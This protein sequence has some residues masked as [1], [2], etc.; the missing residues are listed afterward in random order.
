M[1]QLTGKCLCGAVTFSAAIAKPDVEACHCS[2]CRRWTSGPFLSVGH[3]GDVAF[4]GADDI[5]VYASSEWAE[6]AFCR[7]CGTTLYYRL[8]GQ[9]HYAFSAGALDDDAA[10]TLTRQIFI[11][12]KPGYYDFANDTAKL[13]GE[14][15]FAAF[16]A[17]KSD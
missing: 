15:V 16:N 6:R 12:E 13:T 7:R 2:M 9:D 14:E 10:L 3:D 17:N 5:A 1:P 8:R 4:T 11:E